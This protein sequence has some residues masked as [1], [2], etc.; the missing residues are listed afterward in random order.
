MVQRSNS[1][2]TDEKKVSF[3]NEEDMVYII[4]NSREKSASDIDT[5]NIIRD[6][7]NQNPFAGPRTRGGLKRIEECINRC[8]I[9][10]QGLGEYNPRQYCMKWYCPYEG[11]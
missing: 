3:S 4:P 10:G 7:Y 6:P 2:W 5:N 9:C 11:G 8:V 1:T